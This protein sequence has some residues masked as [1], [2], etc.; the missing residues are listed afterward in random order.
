MVKNSA[1]S[2]SAFLKDIMTSPVLTINPDALMVNVA[3]LFDRKEFHHVVVI[4]QNRILGVMSDRDILKEV[5]PFV[6]SRLMERSQ[7][8]NTTKRRVHQVMSRGVITAPPEQTVAKGA[9]TMLE[10]HISCLPIVD[11]EESLLGIVTMRDLVACSVD[12][13]RAAQDELDAT[14][15][16]AGILVVIDGVRCYSPHTEIGHMIREAEVAYRK[17]HRIDSAQPAVLPCPARLARSVSRAGS[18]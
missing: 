16:D 4:E 18:F 6:G 10:H 12:T 8:L 2:T 9:A 5:S 1:V 11:K 14:E 3:K 13:D 7:D 17:K 15:H